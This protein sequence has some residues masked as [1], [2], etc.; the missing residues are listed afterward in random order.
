MGRKKKPRVDQAAAIADEKNNS[1]PTMSMSMMM[2]PK[3]QQ[4]LPAAAADAAV[5][6][7][8]PTTTTDAALPSFPAPPPKAVP[9]RPAS[10]TVTEILTDNNIINSEVESKIKS[11]TLQTKSQEIIDEADLGTKPSSQYGLHSH[12]GDL[13]EEDIYVS[14]G[15]LSS[16]EEEQEVQQDDTNNADD[17][18]PPDSR[19]SNHNKQL[20]L[21]ITTSKMGLMRRGGISSLL[22]T[23]VNRTWVRTDPT[24]TTDENNEPTNNN[25]TTPSEQ[26]SPQEPTDP[27]QLL[28][29]QQQKIEAA[30]QSA[31]ILE[32]SENAGRDPCLFSKRTAFDIRMDQIEDKPWTTAGTGGGDLTDYFNY[33][34]SEE[35]WLEYSERQMNVRQELTD[36]SKQKRLPDPAIVQVVPRA[37]KV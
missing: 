27:A 20:E 28:L 5:L 34:L 33:G 6:M 24:T 10:D 31:R 17:T 23:Q 1:T 22:N 37:P 32:S 21:V 14:D 36:A 13:I 30:K 4:P 11:A 29:L 12:S 25:N 26:Q 16:Q 3:K 8:P 19:N 2:I 9:P 7:P 35:D 15:S 18:A